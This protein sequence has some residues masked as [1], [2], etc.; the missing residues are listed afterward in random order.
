MSESL[1]LTW[2]PVA[3][4]IPE[5][6]K[7]AD[8]RPNSLTFLY[9]PEGVRTP[10]LMTASLEKHSLR[11]IVECRRGSNTA[12]NNS[13]RAAYYRASSLA[14]LSSLMSDATGKL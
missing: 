12:S 10:D 14:L 7:A 1:E 11:S 4:R 5:K 3:T 9:G 6:R 2:Q 8:W 13:R